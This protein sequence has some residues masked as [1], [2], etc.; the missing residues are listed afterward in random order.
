MAARAVPK[1]Q[2]IYSILRQRILEGDWDPGA[3]MPPQQELADSFGVTLM[4]LRQS[5]AALEA[6]G[7]VTAVRGRGTYVAE[8]PVDINLG[9]LSSFAAQMRAAGVAM[10]TE[11]I[12]VEMVEN[13]EIAGSLGI[14]GSLRRIVR[15]RSVAGLPFGLQRSYLDGEIEIDE[16]ALSTSGGSLYESIAASAGWAIVQARE[17]IEAVA[18]DEA[19]STVLQAPLGHPALR[20]VRTSINQFDQPFLYDE[21]LLVGGRSSIAADRTTD[22]LSLQFGHLDT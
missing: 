14:A 18:L 13:S 12:A 22:R 16:L 20:S 7:L 21:A 3:K 15:L 9:N 19:D 17:S 4:T 1:Y 2:A 10:T 6:D 8:R 11:V 5:L